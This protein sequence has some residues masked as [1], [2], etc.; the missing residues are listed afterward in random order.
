MRTNKIFVYVRAGVITEKSRPGNVCDDICENSCVDSADASCQPFEEHNSSRIS[1]L[2][3][4]IKVKSSISFLTYLM[5]TECCIF[6]IDSRTHN[7]YTNV[8][9]QHIVIVVTQLNTINA[10][11]ILCASFICIVHVF[12]N[13]CRVGYE[14]KCLNFI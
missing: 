2:L 5:C 1:A 7:L 8:Q 13:A 3:F 9:S 4:V 6:N 11:T 10:I 14:I 12:F